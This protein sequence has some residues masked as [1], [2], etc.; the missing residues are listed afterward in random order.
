MSARRREKP[1]DSVEE[2]FQRFKAWQQ[3]QGATAAL[4]ESESEA[5]PPR[6]APHSKNRKKKSVIVEDPITDSSSSEDEDSQTKILVYRRDASG[7]KYRSYEPASH[8]GKLVHN[9]HSEVTKQHI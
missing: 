6:A 8:L 7:I 4:S 9:S 2:E 1:V 3:S 5:S